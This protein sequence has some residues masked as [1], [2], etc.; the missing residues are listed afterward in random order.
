MGVVDDV[1]RDDTASL[2]E[3]GGAVNKVGREWC[4]DDKKI[5]DDDADSDNVVVGLGEGD[6]NSHV[7]DSVFPAKQRGDTHPLKEEGH[8]LN[9]A[10]P[11]APILDG[12]DP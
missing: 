10:A 3:G 11:K 7:R 1:G 12:G 2:P 8:P 4:D 9:T 5:V 6:Y